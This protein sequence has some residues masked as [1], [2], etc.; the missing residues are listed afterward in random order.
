VAGQGTIGAE[1]REQIDEIDSVFISVGGGGLISGIAGYLKSLRPETKIIGCSPENSQVMMQSVKAGK[2]LDLPSLPTLSDGTAGGLEPGAI[3]FE[4]C[5]KL[6]DD[7]IT[8]SEEEIAESMR[9]FM[10]AHNMTIEGAAGV[11]LASSLKWKDRLKDQK[12]V[13]IICGGNISPDTL[14]SV[15]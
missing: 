14:K 2:I 1:L 11:A 8:V 3:T 15:L 13:I 7:W 6:V 9:L 12:I 4:Y 10:P 5:S